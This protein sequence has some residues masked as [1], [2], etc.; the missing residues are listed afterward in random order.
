VEELFY[1]SLVQPTQFVVNCSIAAIA[2]FLPL[3][4]L[5]AWRQPG[6]TTI[7]EKIGSRVRVPSLP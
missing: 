4:A 2:C 1:V 7:P 3:R 5:T 6:L